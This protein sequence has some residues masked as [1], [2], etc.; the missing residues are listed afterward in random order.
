VGKISG[1]KREPVDSRSEIQVARLATV[2]HTLLLFAV[3]LY[4]SAKDMVNFP[5]EYPTQSINLILK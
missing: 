2:S 4:L 1:K 5:L 3:R